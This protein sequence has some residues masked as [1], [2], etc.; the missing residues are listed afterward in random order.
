MRFFCSFFAHSSFD[1]NPPLLLLLLHP[2][3]WGPSPRVLWSTRSLSNSVCFITC[4][5]NPGKGKHMFSRNTTKFRLCMNFF[6][7]THFN[8][9]R[10][11][12]KKSWS[13]ERVD[14]SSAD[15][16]ECRLL[17]PQAFF[18]SCLLDLWLPLWPCTP[19]ARRKRSVPLV[20]QSCHCCQNTS[21]KQIY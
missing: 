8:P 10:S 3:L 21:G 7:F 6:F 14:P 11:N 19:A 1:M 17:C 15:S 9:F 18:S 2:S 13:W 5:S 16:R 12:R 20:H 4:L